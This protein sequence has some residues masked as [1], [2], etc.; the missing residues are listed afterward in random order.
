MYLF[1]LKGISYVCKRPKSSLGIVSILVDAV[2]F[3]G[4]G[5]LKQ[6]RATPLSVVGD[7]H[8]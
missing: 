3:L 7:S 6:A 2:S 1:F 4:N 8:S 5:Q